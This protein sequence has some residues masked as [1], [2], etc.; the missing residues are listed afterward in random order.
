MELHHLHI[1]KAW[2]RTVGHSQAVSGF[3]CRGRHHIVHRWSRAS[4]QQ[5]RFGADDEERTPTDV[6]K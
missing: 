5:R 6:D 3:L 1:D 4:G 2:L